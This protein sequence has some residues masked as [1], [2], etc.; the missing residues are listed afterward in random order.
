MKTFNIGDRVAFDVGIH[1]PD[2]R[3]GVVNR[4]YL[5]PSRA[6]VEIYEDGDQSMPWTVHPAYVKLDE[7]DQRDHPE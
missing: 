7:G 2:V 4:V 5:P 3:R 6:A 1:K